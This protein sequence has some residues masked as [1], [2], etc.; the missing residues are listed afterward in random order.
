M[1]GRALASGTSGN[2]L[3]VEAAGTN[4]FG[5]PYLLFDYALNAATADAKAIAQL[6]II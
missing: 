3:L 5:G 4:P 6:H 2:D 1:L